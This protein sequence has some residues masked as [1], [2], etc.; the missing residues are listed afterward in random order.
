MTKTSALVSVEN[1]Y[2]AK[3]RLNGIAENTPLQRNFNLSEQYG[4]NLFLK[5]EDLQV[6][7]SFKIRGAYN[8][9]AAT[10]REELEK[11]VVCASAGNHA[12]GVAYACSAMKVKGKIYMPSVTPRQKVSK[13]KLF[14]KEYVEVI[15]VG[16]TFDDSYLEARK[17]SEENGTVFVHP[18]DDDK[19]I[20]G[21]G[22]I[23]LEILEKITEPIDYVFV[24][25]GGG[26]L[27]SGIGSCFKQ[28]SPQTKIIGIEPKGAAAMQQ[29]LLENFRFLL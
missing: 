7:R 4:C 12:Q 14:G 23:G 8:K 3:V 11:G 9:M 5:R 21:Q 15:L 6:V 1:L 29:S 2:K 26:G 24:A 10:P 17:D 22:T 18:F 25:I 13:V 19:T 28:L 20:E 16:D 27:A